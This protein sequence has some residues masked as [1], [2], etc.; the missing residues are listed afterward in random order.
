MIIIVC[1]LYT[2]IRQTCRNVNEN[3]FLK[4]KDNFT[5]CVLVV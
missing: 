5:V 3:M 1:K 4:E 2:S